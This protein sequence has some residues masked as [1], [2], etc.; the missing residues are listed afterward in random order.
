MKIIRLILKYYKLIFNIVAKKRIEKNDTDVNSMHTLLVSVIATAP[1][2]W[3]YSCLA[4]TTI[5]TKEPFVV[6]VIAS[7]IHLITPF[8][9][10]F[11]SSTLLLSFIFLTAGVIHQAA[12]A[13]FTGGFESS[14]IIWFG[15][16]PMLG[17]IVAGRKGIVLMGIIVFGIALCYLGLQLSGFIFP[18]LITPTGHLIGQAMMVF[19]WILLSMIMIYIFTKL[20]DISNE[21]LKIASDKIHTLFRIL[22][23]DVANPVMVI[24][25]GVEFLQRPG[26]SEER[27]TQITQRIERAANSTQEVITSVRNMYAVES[28]KGELN[29]SA[30]P[31]SEAVEY[32]EFVLK[33]KLDDKKI[34]LIYCKQSLQKRLVLVDPVIFNNQVVLNIITNAAKFSHQGSNIHINVDETD[35]QDELVMSIRDEGVG[36][37]DDLVNNLF[38]ITA[39]T[40]RPG[41]NGEKGTG[42]GMIIMKAFV[43]KFG[44]GVRVF[45]KQMI[46][47]CKDHGTEFL[48]TLKKGIVQNEKIEERT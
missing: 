44:G 29:I 21:T 14:I 22:I 1:L 45:S 35:Q 38:E 42:F 48:I 30:Y 28:G 31:I 3:G 5:S 15:V 25:S 36:M 26:T 7:I 13:F 11:T 16:I 2:M 9:Y 4:Y 37:P 8:L 47:G 24:I 27:K 34:N 23:H 43:E 32:V 20:Q 46:D 19:G 17:G 39:K 6:G 10:R 12:F 40:S 41:T 18:N 33:E